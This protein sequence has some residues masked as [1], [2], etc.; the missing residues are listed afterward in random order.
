MQKS[1]RKADAPPL[2]ALGIL[3]RL[4]RGKMIERKFGEA[5]KWHDMG[6]ACYRGKW[7]G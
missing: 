5:E 4:W 1:L 3:P 2:P 7:H 6:R